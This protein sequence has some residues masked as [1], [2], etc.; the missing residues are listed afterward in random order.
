MTP[1]ELAATF[2]AYCEA[3]TN[4]ANVKKYSRYFKGEYHAYGLTNADMLDITSSMIAQGATLQL[5][6]ETAPLLIA[7]QKY[8]EPSFIITMTDKFRKSFDRRVFD[9]IAGWYDSGIHNWA[10]ADMLGMSMLPEFLFKNIVTVD[11]FGPW[12]TAGN[13][14]KRRSVPVTFIKWIKKH[15]DEIVPLFPF[16]E[17]LMDDPVREVHQGIGWYLREAWKINPTATETFLLKHRETAARLIY[18]YACEKMDADRK[19][20]FRRT[21]KKGQ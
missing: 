17:S 13:P 16:L 11:D 14:F 7:G 10:H 4:E 15:P 12:L 19:Q 18:Q 2:K 8:E 20:L 21:I 1:S 6:L 3:H 9:A 5:V